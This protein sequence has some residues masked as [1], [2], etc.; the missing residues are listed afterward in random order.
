[1]TTILKYALHLLGNNED[2]ESVEM[3][4]K[5][6]YI[7]LFLM[8]G[9]IF[10]QFGNQTTVSAGER[11]T[12]LEKLVTAFQNENIV[13]TGWSLYAREHL[14]NPKSA[15]EVKEYA[16][17]LKKEYPN[18]EWSEKNTS[19]EW[20]VQ[21]KSPTSKNHQELLQIMATHT[22]KPMDAY[23]VYRVSGKKWN[24]ESASFFASDQYKNRLNDI[25]H[26]M[27]T[28]FSCIKGQLGD[29]IDSS[30]TKTT[31]NLMTFFNAKE[32]ESLK[33]DHFM[34]V[35]ANSPMLAGSIDH[36]NLQIGVRTD[37]LGAGT[38]V[39]VGTPIITIEY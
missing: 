2:K 4:N 22:K 28:I 11:D 30:L 10:F 24:K 12:D 20:E 15:D 29:K 9:I 31:N 25:F 6:M 14:V 35:T 23:I 38:T 1:V 16:R 17:K 33:E 8:V 3:K 5:T 36:R 27:P 26:G 37:G 39:V 18:W 21:A 32:I 13:L 7:V 19:Q 34:S